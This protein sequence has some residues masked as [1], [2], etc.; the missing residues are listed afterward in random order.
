LIF[1]ACFRGVLVLF[2]V[3]RAAN[4]WI[5]GCTPSGVGRERRKRRKG[6]RKRRRKMSSRVEV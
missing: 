2:T 6:I 3:R 4:Y 5:G 1:I